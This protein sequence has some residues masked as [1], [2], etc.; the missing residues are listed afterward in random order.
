MAS[1]ELELTKYRPRL[2]ERMCGGWLAVSEPG[3]RFQIA[4]VG[5]TAERAEARFVAS[6]QEWEA[7]DA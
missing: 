1:Q 5:E 6:I 2:I 7:L 3:S 4:V